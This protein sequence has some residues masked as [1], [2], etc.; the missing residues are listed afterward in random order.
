MRVPLHTPVPA[1]PRA[2]AQRC[3]MQRFRVVVMVL[4]LTLAALL[5][6]PLFRHLTG[7]PLDPRPQDSQFQAGPRGVP[8]GV[9]PAL[10]GPSPHWFMGT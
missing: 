4:T 5:G 2:Y 10:T 8:S 1:R 9:G 6:P 3:L 7:Q